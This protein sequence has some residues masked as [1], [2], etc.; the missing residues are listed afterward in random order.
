[1]KFHGS[2]WVSLAFLAP[3]AAAWGC[4][5]TVGAPAG[6]EGTSDEDGPVV[7]PGEPPV[8][9]ACSAR[10]GRPRWKLSGHT[11][12]QTRA[13]VTQVFGPE[14]AADDQVQ[15]LLANLPPN[16]RAKGFDTEQKAIAGQFVDGY[17]ALAG[18]LGALAAEKE[19]VRGSI[20]AFLGMDC[21]RSTDLEEACG[22]ELARAFAG[23]PRARA[24]CRGRLRLHDGGLQSQQG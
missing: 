23:C 5:G 14:A 20:E 22:Q 17:V 16:L 8:A 6:A 3:F 15:S 24:G 13:I 7:S 18:R 19:S 1:M 2:R 10:E 12:F 11:A 4:S 21:G 9:A